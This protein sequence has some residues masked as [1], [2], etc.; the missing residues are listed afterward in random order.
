MT[1]LGFEPMF[2]IVR[3]VLLP[4]THPSVWLLSSPHVRVQVSPPLGLPA[5][6]SAGARLEGIWRLWPGMGRLYGRR[7]CRSWKSLWTSEHWKERMGTSQREGSY[8]RGNLKSLADPKLCVLRVRPQGFWGE[9]SR[10]KTAKQA[11]QWLNITG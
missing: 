3:S 10:W 4:G 7:A 9:N 11:S 6:P 2:L 8:K 1:R 5:H